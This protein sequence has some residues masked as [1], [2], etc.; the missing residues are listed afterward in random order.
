MRP[1]RPKTMIIEGP[2]MCGKTQ[3]A[4]SL[5]LH[6][7]FCNNVDFSVWND[8]ALYNVFDDIPF[9]FLPCKKAILGSQSDFTVN[10]KYRKK[11]RVKGGL[12]SIILCN[13]DESYRV[14]L[15]SSDMYE[16]STHNVIHITLNKNLY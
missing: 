8:K 11:T 4:R 1:L 14:A 9:Q 16:W 13:P 3:W 7:Y 2:S 5:G 15:C 6:N 10:E 12:P